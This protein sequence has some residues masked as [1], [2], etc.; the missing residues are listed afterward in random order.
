MAILFNGTTSFDPLLISTTFRGWVYASIRPI[1][2]K[3]AGQTVKVGRKVA[4]AKRAK[5]KVDYE[6]IESH[7]NSSEKLCNPNS[8][9][10]GWALMFTTVATLEL[11]GKQLWW[12]DR[13]HA[14]GR[15][16]LSDSTEAGSLRLRAPIVARCFTFGRRDT[17]VSRF[18]FRPSKR[19]ISRIRIQRTLTDRG[20]RCR[21][22]AWP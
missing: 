8:L 19:S 16:R 21:P 1:A 3:I 2:Q 20:H 9:M 7:P 13:D 11:A 22:R 15:R 6:E 18:R 17:P 5:S 14:Q 10:T 4:M 12:F